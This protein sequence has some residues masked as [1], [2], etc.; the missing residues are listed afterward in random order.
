[1]HAPLAVF[2]ERGKQHCAIFGRGKGEGRTAHDTCSSCLRHPL[3]HF[4][5]QPK[6]S[7]AYPFEERGGGLAAPFVSSPL[8]VCCLH[9]F[10]DLMGREC[11]VPRVVGRS[12][13]PLCSILRMKRTHCLWLNVS[14]SQ[15]GYRS[16]V[17]S[18][19][20]EASVRFVP[21]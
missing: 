9:I 14:A 21:Q 10:A 17:Y 1:M 15:L 16:W 11:M 6:Y 18:Q 20:Y 12:I 3:R 4:L 5:L 13:N 8:S 7:L 19:C 2:S